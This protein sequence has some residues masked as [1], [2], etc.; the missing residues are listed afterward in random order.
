MGNN[1]TLHSIALGDE[2]IDFLTPLF[3][4]IRRDKV[5][6]DNFLSRNGKS[7]DPFDYHVSNYGKDSFKNLRFYKIHSIYD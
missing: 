2:N 6:Y 4:F 5:D 1:L 3:K 7:V